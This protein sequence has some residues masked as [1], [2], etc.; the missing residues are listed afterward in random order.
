MSG[1]RGITMLEL[2]TVLAIVAIVAA[3]AVPGAARA[4]AVLSGAQGPH[5]LALVLRA[6][7]AEAQNCGSPVVVRVA[8]S[9]EYVVTGSGGAELLSGSIG[10][11]VTSNY[12]G[13]T[14]E[15][16]ARG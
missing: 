15:F 13:G 1:Q 12:P 4:H 10:A 11:G 7:Q 16:S 14:L 3:I 8:A 6:A 2:V 9:G 5:R